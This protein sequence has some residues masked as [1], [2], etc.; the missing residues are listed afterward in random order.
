MECLQVSCR[1][2]TRTKSNGYE[3]PINNYFIAG[4]LFQA[5]M[6]FYGSGN[7][8]RVPR[9]FHQCMHDCNHTSSSSSSLRPQ[10]V[11]NVSGLK[12]IQTAPGL[13]MT[14]CSV[15]MLPKVAYVMESGRPLGFAS[16]VVKVRSGTKLQSTTSLST[17]S[18]LA[19]PGE[20]MNHPE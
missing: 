11:S 13:Q 2:S 15:R 1:S 9:V 3:N 19:S 16:L 6:E 20:N 14:T 5:G 12:W 7:G 17:A 8:G 18:P 4:H 10:S